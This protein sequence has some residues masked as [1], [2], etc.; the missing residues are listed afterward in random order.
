M[1]RRN[2]CSINVRYPC[3]QKQIR[4][5]CRS[6]F[7][8][9][10]SLFFLLVIKKKK[11]TLILLANRVIFRHFQINCTNQS[12]PNQDLFG[13]PHRILN[14]RLFYFS[15]FFVTAYC[16]NAI[17]W[18]E[19]HSFNLE[20]VLCR[21]IHFFLYGTIIQ[22]IVSVKKRNDALTYVFGTCC[23]QSVRQEHSALKWAA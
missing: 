2:S 3:M 19:S 1:R 5:K 6:F 20:I 7:F 8:N 14:S 11:T 10:P 4:R 17:I 21:C 13:R 23:F 18:K 12:H 22:S 16:V 9:C 15:F